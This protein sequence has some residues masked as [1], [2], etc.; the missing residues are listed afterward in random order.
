[1]L[2]LKEAATDIGLP[3]DQSRDDWNTNNN[4]ESAFRVFDVVFL[5]LTQNKR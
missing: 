3:A 1:M 5:E 2:E 4:I